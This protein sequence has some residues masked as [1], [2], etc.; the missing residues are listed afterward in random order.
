MAYKLID[1]ARALILANRNPNRAISEDHRL[2]E[3]ENV[4]RFVYRNDDVA[5]PCNY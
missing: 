4:M 3:L 2:R 1:M 5:Q